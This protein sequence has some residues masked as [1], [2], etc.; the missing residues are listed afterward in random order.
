[1]P[2]HR[3]LTVMSSS[4]SAFLIVLSA[5]LFRWGSLQGGGPRCIMCRDRREHRSSSIEHR[6]SSIG[7][8]VDSR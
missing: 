8:L 1:M 2:P 4:S 7:A 3:P 6:A 5:L